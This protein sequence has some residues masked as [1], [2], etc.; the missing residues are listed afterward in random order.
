MQWVQGAMNP[1]PLK[2]QRKLNL[3]GYTHLIQDLSLAMRRVKLL[4]RRSK[5]QAETLKPRLQNSLV[6]RSRYLKT[7]QLI[8]L[9]LAETMLFRMRFFNLTNALKVNLKNQ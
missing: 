1:K 6:R 3:T 2:G 4:M 8:I 9:L 5:L 7:H